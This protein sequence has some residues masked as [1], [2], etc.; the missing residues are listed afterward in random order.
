MELLDVFPIRGVQSPHENHRHRQ[1][2]QHPDTDA[3]ARVL[4]GLGHPLHVAHQVAH[5]GVELQRGHG[6]GRDLFPLAGEHIGL[7]TM[8]LDLGVDRTALALE[9]P[10]RIG[11]GHA[12]E[13]E[14]VPAGRLGV[15]AVVGAQVGVEVVRTGAAVAG[16]RACHQRQVG[17]RGAEPFL[18]LARIDVG[19]HGLADLLGRE[20]KV[21]LDLLLADADVLQ[22]VEAHEGGRVAVEAV[23]DEQ[24]GAVLQ[25]CHVVGLVRGLVPGEAAGFGRSGCGEGQAQCQAQGREPAG[26]AFLHR[27]SLEL[28][29]AFQWAAKVTRSGTVLN[30]P[31][32][33]HHGISRKKPK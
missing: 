11:H 23:V 14:V 10:Q 7:V 20:Q 9:L 24:L 32:R 31:L 16:A 18:G 29:C 5:G 12:R 2:Q 28:S 22:A 30:S 33:L 26:N 21:V 19:L 6:A 1:E 4:R 8:L 25:R 17:R 3:D 13:C 15:V 27:V